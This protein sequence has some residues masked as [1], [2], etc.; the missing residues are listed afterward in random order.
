MQLVAHQAHHLVSGPS[1]VGDHKLFE[2]IYKELDE[3][4]DTVAERVVSHFSPDHLNL[5][6]ILMGVTQVLEQLP[7]LNDMK[8]NT[9][10]F[11][12]M[13]HME[14]TLC[15]YCAEASQSGLTL[16]S[17]NMLSNICDRSEIRQ[18]K[19]LGRIR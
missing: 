7:S 15:M 8:D 16:G 9:P 1:F 13:D 11:Q 2:Q 18:Y 19:I 5:A 17:A 4:Y 10:M 14:K 12:L 6:H 3:E